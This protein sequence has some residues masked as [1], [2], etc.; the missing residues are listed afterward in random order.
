MP[1]YVYRVKPAAGGCGVC[2]EGFEKTQRMREAALEKCPQCGAA[3]ERV[4][5]APMLGNVAGKLKG[6][7]DAAIKSA[8]FTKFKRSGK[9]NYEK[10]YGSGPSRLGGG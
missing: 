10:Q 6:P 2:H 7:S 1:T 8:G 9:G 5:Q 4:I 3:I